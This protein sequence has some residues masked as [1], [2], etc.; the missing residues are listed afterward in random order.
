MGYLVVISP[1]LDNY[2]EASSP[3]LADLGLV[4]LESEDGFEPI[5]I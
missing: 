3:E 4:L 2:F 5:F 1:S